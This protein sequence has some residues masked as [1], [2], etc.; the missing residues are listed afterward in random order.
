MNLDVKGTFEWTPQPGQ[1]GVHPVRFTA[2]D[3][4]LSD[5]EQ[6][7]IYVGAIGESLNSNG[8]PESLED[9]AVRI[10]DLF[11]RSDLGT[12]TVK[13]ESVQGIL[14]DVYYSDHALS[15]GMVWQAL[16]TNVEASAA[17][18]S[19]SDDALGLATPRRFYEVPLR[20]DTPGVNEVWGLFRE[21]ID[22]GYELVA[23]PLR[24]DRRFDGDLGEQLAA[25]LAGDDAGAGDQLGD[26]IFIRETNGTWRVLYLDTSNTWREAGGAASTYELAPGAGFFICRH[27]SSN[28][29]VTLSGPVGDPYSQTNSIVPGYNIAGWAKGGSVDLIEVVDGA[30]SGSPVGGATEETAD[31]LIIEKPDGRWQRLMYADGWGAPHDGNWIDLDTGSAVTPQADPGQAVY[32]FRQGGSGNMEVV[33]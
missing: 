20:G 3:G 1:E 32:Y 19:I 9:Y 27:G 25:A 7:K 21:S 28:A 8:I 33:F 29:T 4:S 2:S 22:V 5:E 11:A 23:H 24:S 13:W 17:E 14:Y 6:V 10:T 18:E 15:S 30:V 16:A 12:S 26:E 31:L